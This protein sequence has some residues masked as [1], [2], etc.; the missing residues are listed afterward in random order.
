MSASVTSKKQCVTCNKSGGILTCDGCQQSFC[1][2]HVNEHRQELGG[3]LDDIIQEHDLLQEELG[4][5]TSKKNFLL[6]KI[7]KWEQDSIEKIQAAADT[8]RTNL[9]KL[10]EQSKERISKTCR[11]IT[12][13]LLSHREDDDF[14]E[15]DLDRWK[16]QLHELKLE[17]TTPSG[18]KL[19]PDKSA[20]IYPMVITANDSSN[21]QFASSNASPPTKSSPNPDLQERFVQILGPVNLEEG[22]YLAKHTGTTSDCA[23]IRGRLLYSEGCHTVRFKIEKCKPPYRI[24]FGC[25]SSQTPL[26]KDAFR[27]PTSVGWFGSNQVYEHGR[28]SSNSRKYEYNSSK[29]QANDVLHLTLDCTTMQLRLFHER[30]KTTCVLSVKH[31][32]SPFPWQFLM[33]LCNSGDTVRILPNP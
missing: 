22:G 32:S 25:M 8:A 4:E 11:E 30:L 33:V 24:F 18:A 14:S 23:Y 12:E 29:I 20:P 3:Q 31:N 28:C 19:I 26:K 5:P 17:I 6:K 10:I 13:K 2:Q 16:K 1:G 9:E 7:D 27:S 15:N 21:D